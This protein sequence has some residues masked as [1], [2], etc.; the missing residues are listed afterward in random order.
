MNKFPL[1]PTRLKYG[2]YAFCSKEDC[3]IKKCCRHK[4]HNSNTEYITVAHWY[5]DKR[6]HLYKEE[7]LKDEKN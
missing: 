5:N 1:V 4:C 3:K 2:D 7:V 6:C